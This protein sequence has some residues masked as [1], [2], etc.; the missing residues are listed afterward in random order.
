[1]REV[2]LED[3]HTELLRIAVHDR[4]SSPRFDALLKEVR[5]DVKKAREWRIEGMEPDRKKPLSDWWSGYADLAT[6]I[7]E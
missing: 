3:I 1:M 7:P 4:P 5:Q 6:Y 2:S